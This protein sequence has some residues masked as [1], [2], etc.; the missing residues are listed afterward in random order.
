[1][2]TTK[3]KSYPNENEFENENV[4]QIQLQIGNQNENQIETRKSNRNKKPIEKLVVNPK[5]KIYLTYDLES[6]LSDPQNKSEA[7]NSRNK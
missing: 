3:I 1:M 5:N 6:D 2:Q 7:L 4:N